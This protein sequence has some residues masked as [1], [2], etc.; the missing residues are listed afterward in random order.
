MKEKKPSWKHVPVSWHLLYWPSLYSVGY[1]VLGPC[2]K[3]RQSKRRRRHAMKNGQRAGCGHAAEAPWEEGGGPW[4][5]SHQLW[6]WTSPFIKPRFS[7]QYTGD[8]IPSW[9]GGG[10]SREENQSK[11]INEEPPPPPTLNV[12]N[13]EGKE[14]FKNDMQGIPKMPCIKIE[15]KKRSPSRDPMGRR[16]RNNWGLALRARPWDAEVEEQHGQ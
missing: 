1:F 7:Q 12:L 2:L 15:G 6:A 16:A 10:G 9:E 8:K 5:A 13:S 3:H 11:G 4:P 14:Y